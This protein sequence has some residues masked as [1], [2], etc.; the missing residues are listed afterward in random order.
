MTVLDVYANL[1]LMITTEAMAQHDTE[2]VEALP[3]VEIIA[4]PNV[5]WHVIRGYDFAGLESIL[6]SGILPSKNCDG[7]NGRGFVH[8]VA[9]SVSPAYAHSVGKESKSFLTYTLADGISLAIDNPYIR[10]TKSYGGFDDEIRIPVKVEPERVKGVLLPLKNH[11]LPLENVITNHEPR[12]PEQARSYIERT[13]Q[14]INDLGSR[15][16]DETAHLVDDCLSALGNNELTR[17]QI[18]TLE[19]AF[20]RE[21]S[22]ALTDIYGIE[23]PTVQ[24]LLTIIFQRTN[25]KIL[26]FTYTDQQIEEI[27]ANN[28]EIARI[29]HSKQPLSLG[30]VSLNAALPMPDK[31]LKS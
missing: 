21:Y 10:L 14:H 6:N 8:E 16:S 15:L 28:S 19:H 2:P 5:A 25:K 23:K 3:S 9:L 22:R 29:N 20:M 4:D 12:K 1:Y 7:N 31:P 24:D 11:D 30:I 18:A 26:T 17:E 27:R 13:I